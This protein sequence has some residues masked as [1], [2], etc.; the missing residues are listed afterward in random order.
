MSKTHLTYYIIHHL[1]DKFNP[2]TVL[3]C[4]F[5][6]NEKHP[7]LLQGVRII[8]NYLLSSSV[9]PDLNLKISL[10]S[11]TVIFSMSLLAIC[12]SYSVT[13]LDCVCRNCRISSIRFFNISCS[14]SLVTTAIRHSCSLTSPQSY[15]HHR[16]LP[17][18]TLMRS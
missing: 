5:S 12:P 8:F 7:A 9:M 18:K 10:S 6:M 1:V 17:L 4:K 16:P 14:A 13:R 15:E 11:K 2:G 3:L